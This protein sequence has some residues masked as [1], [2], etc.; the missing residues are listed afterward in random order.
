M[1]GGGILT[2]DRPSVIVLHDSRMA[3]PTREFHLE[4]SNDSSIMCT[5]STGVERVAALSDSGRRLTLWDGHTG[6]RLASRALSS[7]TQRLEFSPDG[8]RLAAIDVN[9]GIHLIECTSGEIRQILPGQSDH[10]HHITV[11]FSPDGTRLA[12]ARDGRETEGNPARILVWD[13]ATGRRLATFPGRPEGQAD[14]MFSPDGKSLLISSR[15]S[16]R[17]WLLATAD[18]D[19]GRQPAG[20]KDEA[21]SISFSPD[22][23]TVATG[24]DD[25][26]ADPTI[27]LWDAVTGR[28][29]RGWRGEEGTVA[30]LEFSPDGRL[31]ATGHLASEKN[32]RIWDAATGQRL[33]TLEGHTD[34]VRAVTFAPDGK[35]LATTSS[36][37]TIR[38]WDGTTWHERTVLQGHADTVH[39]VAY[40]PNGRILAS[41]GNDGDVRLWDM[42][43]GGSAFGAT[44]FAQ[45]VQFDGGRIR[46]RR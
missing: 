36:D 22:G 13:T 45:P 28:L 19:E 2:F 38:I 21:W 4:S 30:A 7:Q 9:E 46:S 6:K 34:R 27:K 44:G 20:H 31:I 16:V 43:P 15:S 40:S 11:A 8:A 26:F 33:A 39:S 42:T 5:V 17:R 35:S 18:G 32:V 41:A 1:R 25:S 37:G 29:I 14:L 23:R 12:T 3:K 24:S 10:L